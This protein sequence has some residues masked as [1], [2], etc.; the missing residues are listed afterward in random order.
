MT[1]EEIIDQA[2]QEVEDGKIH[3]PDADGNIRVDEE[4]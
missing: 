4:E 3:E 1:I 2:W